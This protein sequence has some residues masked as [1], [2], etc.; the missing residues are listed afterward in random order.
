MA[1]AFAFLSAAWGLELT[2]SGREEIEN[3]AES[4]SKRHVE[5][6]I[7]DSDLRKL[8]HTSALPKEI[9][10]ISSDVVPPG[11]YLV[12]IQ[13]VVDITQPTKF[14]ED[15]EGGKWRLLV[16]DLSIGDQ[17]FKAVEFDSTKAL[18]V[19]L[20]PGTKLLLYSTKEWP[21]R[22]QNGHILLGPDAVE[23]L[24]GYV[25]K[26]VES[27]KADKEVKET[28]LL[29][30]TDGVKKSADGEGPPKWV[31]FDPKKAPRG[32]SHRKQMDEE[33]KEWQKGQAAVKSSDAKQG[34]DDES[35]PRFQ[36]E[37]FGD[38]GG[39]ALPVKSQVASNTF[40]HMEKGGGKGKSKGKSDEDGGGGGGKRGRKGRDD[41][42]EEKRAPQATFSLAAAIKPTKAGEL[43]DEALAAKNSAQEDDWAWEDSA[44]GDAAWGAGWQGSSGGGGGWSGSSGGHGRSKGG[45]KG[46][47]GGGKGKGG[48][49]SGGGG[50]RKG[51][52][53]GGGYG[54]SW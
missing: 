25:E 18:G 28:R 14:Q 46:K 12:Q 24:G 8:G 45:G 35:G 40:K 34:R 26:L 15:F 43:P 54:R 11:N 5:E 1:D 9:A 13:K 50:S 31:D 32:T 16:V 33:R 22:V 49:K 27:W 21:L 47:G 38:D 20:P 44:G 30:R 7:K 53:G 19:H 29:W 10:R 17:K 51:G 39:A 4:L 2:A 36:K 3:Q 41:F 48:G 6:Y 37:D 52:G 23:V 42:E